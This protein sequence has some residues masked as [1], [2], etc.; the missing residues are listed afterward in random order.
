[1]ERFFIIDGMAIAYRAYFA[2]ISRPLI[3]SKG[4][5]TSAVFGFVNTL[6]KILKEEK[7][8]HIAVA[9]D[10]PHPTFRHE[11]Y[12]QYKATREKMP[13]DM[14]EQLPY[15]KRIVQAYNIPVLEM[16]GFEAYDIIGTLVTRAASEDL[17]CYM[18]TPDKDYMQLVSER[19]RLYKPGKATDTWE[20]VGIEGVREKFGVRPDQVIEVL[21]LMGDQSDN[22]PGVKGI[23]EKTAIPLVQEFGSIAGIYENLDKLTKKAVRARLEEQR[24]E[25]E[26]S[27]ELVTIDVHVPVDVDP[28][29]LRFSDKNVPLLRE[30]FGELELTRF[31]KELEVQQQGAMFDDAPGDMT[32]AASRP[33]TYVTVRTRAQLD[34]MVA[35]I[36]R[37]KEFCFDTET[38]GLDPLQSDLVGL[39]FAVRPAHAWYVP[40]NAELP[41]A[42][43]LAAVRP[44]FESGATVIGQNLKFDLLVL[45]AHG[46][47]TA[48]PLYDTM[49][50]AYILRPE[51]DHGMDALAMQHLGYR[52]IS[53]SSL[54]GKGK[55]QLSMSDIPV[56]EVAEYAAED[57]DVTLQLAHVLRGEIAKTGQEKLLAEMEFPLVHVLAAMEYHGVKIDTDTLGEISKEMEL[58]VDRATA[59]IHRMAEGAFNINSPKQLGEV[60]FE[61]LRLPA[62]KKTKT[63]YSTDVSVLES[64]QGMHPVIDEILLYRQLTKLKGTY[65]D[66]LP[67][68]INPRSGRVHTSY[69]QAVAA[70]GRLSSTDPNLQNIPI[71]TEAGRE[72]RRAFVA[73]NEEYLILSADYSQIELRLAAEIS[74]DEGLIEA[75]DQ[76]EDIH[77]ST[78]MRLFDL[79]AE[80]VN[81]EQRRRAKTTNF[82][83]L[84]GISAFGLAQRLGIDNA[85]AKELIDLYFEKYPRI[86]EYITRTIGFAKENGFVETLLGRRRYI[87][88]INAKNRNIRSFAERTAINAPIQGTAADMIKVAMIHIHE[89]MQRGFAKSRLIMQVHDELVFEAHR[90]EVEE[91]KDM[92]VERM[93][94]AM[95]LRVRIEVDA[96]T[97]EN[98]LEA[99]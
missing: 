62:R 69:N 85:D 75:F 43:I 12:D 55:N 74:G 49:L 28:H 17:E 14:V 72:I 37:E 8:D 64:L 21:G 83:I 34:D 13:E 33:H 58:Q 98:W 81:S 29:D 4:M 39:S 10:T 94:T 22:I 84:Y 44:L 50:A 99:H 71:R 95:K 57:A 9:F 18:V 90:D 65:V 45:R 24:A 51:G 59:E 68:L 89:E 47:A 38:G 30:L 42:D 52:P 53:I 3:N 70:T 80:E 92:V 86:N 93:R 61:R 79:R 60:L 16:P 32:S 63:G 91:L 96:G 31:L 25:A 54:I 2:F 88:D 41:E 36:L 48:Q 97:G 87:P 77:T 1:M 11:R 6:E 5:N 19:V 66:A 82:G 27:R 73:E 35:E 23:G 20:I 46:I 78:A 15:L 40:V 67:R 26:L 76:G 7:P 56:D